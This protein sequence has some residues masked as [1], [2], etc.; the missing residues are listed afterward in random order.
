MRTGLVALCSESPDPG[1]SRFS[2]V[3]TDPFLT[4]TVRGDATL[5]RTSTGQRRLS[6]NP[7]AHLGDLLRHCQIDPETGHPFPLGGCFGYWGY[8][9][10]R[11]VEPRLARSP[12]PPTAWPCCHVGFYDSLVVFDHTRGRGWIVATGLEPSGTG[13]RRRAIAARDR[14][15]Q[16]VEALPGTDPPPTRDKPLASDSLTSSLDRAAYVERVVRAQCLIRAGDIYQVNLSRRLTRPTRHV[17]WHLYQRLAAAS[18]APFAGFYHAGACQL[19]SSSPEIFLR[20]TD[21]DIE[22]RPIK[23][24]RPRHPDPQ[25]DRQMADELQASP[26]ENAEL[27][28]ITDLLRNDL[29]RVCEYG[30][31]RVPEIARLESHPHVHHLVSTVAGRLRPNVT[32]LDALAACFPGGSITGAPKIRAMEIIDQLEPVARGPYTGCLGYI[33]FN[34][35]SQLSILIRTA[36]RTAAWTHFHTGAGIV[37][38]SDPEAEFDETTAKARGFLIATDPEP[39]DRTQAVPPTPP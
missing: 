23:G 28:M 15:R 1:R 25:H 19:I 11:F 34:R 20:L 18:P 29:G 32:H 7:W 33:G 13:S 22:T 3:A 35:Q 17:P 12:H 5:V 38:D 39:T 30:T 10:G 8:D 37:A 2:F 36:I 31:V 6:G 24:T 9:L 4:F 21:R 27:L 26:K 14:W 16:R